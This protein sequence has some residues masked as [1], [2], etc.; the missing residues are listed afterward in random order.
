MW[1]LESWT[2]CNR[3]KGYRDKLDSYCYCLK[4]SATWWFKTENKLLSSRSESQKRKI[5]INWAKISVC[6][7]AFIL[8]TPGKKQ[9]HFSAS[10]DHLHSLASDFRFYIRRF[11]CSIF[12]SLWLLSQC[13]HIHWLW[14]PCLRPIWLHLLLILLLSCSVVTDSLWPHGLQ[15]SRL[16]CLSQ[17]LRAC[18]NSLTQWCQPNIPFSSCLQS[19]PA[20]GA[21]PM[22]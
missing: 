19:F 12:S 18:S 17:S 5:Q 16:P 21:F 6:R 9:W 7:P 4:V 15:H 22:N 10:H 11:Q 2:S 1:V 20:S 13:L 8:E 3:K 14:S